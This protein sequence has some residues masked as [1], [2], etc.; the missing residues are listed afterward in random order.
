[1]ASQF[2]GNATDLK[3]AEISNEMLF[4]SLAEI[5]K[6]DSYFDR[7][8]SGRMNTNHTYEDIVSDSSQVATILRQLGFLV[9]MDFKFA[10]FLKKQSDDSDF[11]PLDG[12]GDI[13]GDAAVA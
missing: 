7:H 12:L 11:I 1:M 10:S 8:L 6:W 13:W 3:A 9:P 2:I 5:S 4:S